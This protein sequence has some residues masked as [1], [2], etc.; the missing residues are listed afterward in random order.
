MAERLKALAALADDLS[1]FISIHGSSKLSIILAP[2][3]PTQFVASIGTRYTHR[4]AGKI[5]KHK[6]IF[7]YIN[8]FALN[9]TVKHMYSNI[10]Y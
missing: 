8:I 4:H 3:D 10:Y 7:I 2:G 9:V 1:S 5:F 6:Y